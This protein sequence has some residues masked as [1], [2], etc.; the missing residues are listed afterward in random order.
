MVWAVGFLLTV[1][2]VVFVGHP[3]F[4]KEASAEDPLERAIAQRRGKSN[5]R[6]LAARAAAATAAA[7]GS[8]VCGQCGATNLPG[9]RFCAGCGAALGK[10][11]PSCGKEYDAGDLFCAG[12]GVKL[13]GR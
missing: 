9:D 1:I 12:C 2:V 7:G 8:A 11:C 5:K 10:C 13:A 4:V 6:K 3:L